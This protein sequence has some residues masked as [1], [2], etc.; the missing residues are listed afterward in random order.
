MKVKL[1]QVRLE[2]DPGPC[3][4]AGLF[5]PLR[6]VILVLLLSLGILGLSQAVPAEDLPGQW[7][8][9][10]PSSKSRQEVSY[11]EAGGKFYLAGGGT[12]HERYDPVK[13]SWSTVK[14]LPKDLDHIQG[15][16]LG[17][18]IYYIGGLSSFPGP[19]VNTV[20]IYDPASDTFSFGAPMPE[21]RGRGGGGVAVY[22][23]KI[24]YAGGLHNGEVVPWFDVYDPAADSWQRLPDMPVA[25]DHFHAAVVD[26][27]FYAIGGRK[28]AINQTITANHAYDFATNSWKTGLA[29]LPTARGGFAA[30]ALGGEIL[31]IGGEGNGLTYNTVEAYD[32]ATNGWRELAPM[33]TARH[34]I[35]AAVC[36]GGIYVAAGGKTQ[37]GGSPTNAHEAFSPGVTRVC[38]GSPPDIEAP[39]TTITAGPSGTVGTNEAAFDFSSSEANSTFACKLDGASFAPCS[40][41][42]SYGGLSD[43]PQ[44]FR[45]V[46]TDAAG[47]T[48]PSPAS[49]SWAVDTAVDASDPTISA[50]RPAPGARLRDRTPR[51][52]AVVTD[53]EEDLSADSMDL[54]V[55]GR[56]RTFDYSR[57]TGK[58]IHTS[59]RLSGGRHTVRVEATDGTG[60][61]AVRS[62]GFKVVRR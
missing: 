38:G 61:T 35:Q 8:N 51:V 27:R 9:L 7:R 32:P 43:G 22:G 10:V 57:D 36:D 24:Y 5:I 40:P 39:E 2:S 56:A 19:H 29:P 33:P 44:I 42:K 4:R 20:Y 31:V 45:V 14:P 37:G 41:P 52:G 50:P 30:A 59:K 3:G 11:V 49:R 16:E 17:G 25:R 26:G 1:R 60:N 12:L 62:W 21:G 47:N 13:D 58:L 28:K 18:K 46:A 55:D 34:G 54:Y 6:T 23:G 53:A 48:D 15:V